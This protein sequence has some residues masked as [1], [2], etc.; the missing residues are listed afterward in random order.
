MNEPVKTPP[1]RKQESQ[2]LLTAMK[3]T[4]TIG[5]LSLTL[6][7]WG[8]LSRAEAHNV[9][10]AAQATPATLTAAQNLATPAPDAA[11]VAAAPADGNRANV[12]PARSAAAASAEEEGETSA[13]EETGAS[14]TASAA[15]PASQPKA[16]TRATATP[17]PK[18]TATPTPLPKAPTATDAPASAD[19]PASTPAPSPT[20]LFTLD[21][22]QWVQTQDGRDVAVVRDNQGQLWY[23][24]GT[25]IPRIENGQQPEFQPQPVNRSGRTRRS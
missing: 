2:T 1:S 23:V 15:A 4:T 24:M 18:A 13:V 16:K 21:V 6:A 11:R 25:D 9:A 7:G 5:A 14:E 3:M 20:P 19:A 8:L 22:V 17:L 12:R 10:Q